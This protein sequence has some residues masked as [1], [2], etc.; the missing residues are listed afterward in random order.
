VLAGAVVFTAAHTTA[1]QVLGVLLVAAGI[2][3]VR[4]LR[5][6]RGIGFGIA[7]AICIASYTVVDKH[8]VAHASPLAYLELVTSIIG[9]A[10]LAGFTAVRGPAAVRAAFGWRPVVAG[11]A[12]FAAYGLVLWAL[13]LASA[14]SVAAVRETGVLFA[15]GLAALFLKERVTRWRFAGVALV[16]VGIALLSL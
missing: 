15:T 12:S 5:R 6:G 4:G 2:L 16:A 7:I 11:L 3:L 1:Q 13:Q 10:Y 8:G 9:V 14:A